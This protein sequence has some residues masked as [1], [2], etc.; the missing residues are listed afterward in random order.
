MSEVD[1]RH[2]LNTFALLLGVIVFGT[3]GFMLIEGF[4]FINAFFMTII[5]VST[6]GFET[7]EPL[8]DM[9][10]IFTAFLI[11]LSLGTFA[12]GVSTFTRYILSGVFRN[13]YKQSKMKKRIS[14]LSNHIIVCGYGRVGKQSAL[15][16]L[17]NKEKVVI[18]D[19]QISNIEE[20]QQI[21][22]L[23]YILGD[24]TQDEVLS[25]AL[26][27]DAKAL[28]TTFPNDADNLFIVLT[29]K[30]MNP[31]LKIIS[32]AYDVHSD[33]KLKRAGANN[34]IMPD[35]VG[36]QRMAKLVSQPDVVE[37]IEHILLQTNRDVFLEELTCNKLAT[38]FVN[39]SI[40]ELDIRNVSGANIVGVRQKK[41][42]YIINPSPDIMLTQEDKIFVLGNLEQ[43][44]KLK[45]IL[46][47][48]T[49]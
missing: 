40:R 49:N 35:K 42:N 41:G 33:I 28:I 30:Q 6:V 22:E 43:I 36:G 24:A 10:K 9:G 32:R 14:K 18:I 11:I 15:E 46:L 3:S 20:I 7:V 25:E 27:N 48:G 38:C 19:N 2:I 13:F 39:K 23:M 12:Y 17:E 37:F 16:L 8:S 26:I 5:S 29:A 31:K 44:D 47:S 4:S 45:Q 21:P 1:K 34:V